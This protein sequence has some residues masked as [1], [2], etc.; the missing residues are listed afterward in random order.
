MDQSPSFAKVCKGFNGTIWVFG[1][2][3]AVHVDH[4][5]STAIFTP[6]WYFTNK[7]WQIAIAWHTTELLCFRGKVLSHDAIACIVDS[8]YLLD[9]ILNLI[10]LIFR[11]VWV[12]HT[13]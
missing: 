9:L 2:I 13:G 7:G 5:L 3:N 12:I 6:W 1:L 10:M 8:P 4:I 11:R